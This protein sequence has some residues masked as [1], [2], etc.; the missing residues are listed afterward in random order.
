MRGRC[1][2]ERGGLGRAPCLRRPLT[3]ASPRSAR[4]GRRPRP[5][6]RKRGEANAR[7][8][9]EVRCACPSIASPAAGPGR[10]IFPDLSFAL[11]RGE[12]IAVTGRNGAGKSSLLA[13]LAGR[14]EPESG[15]DRGGGRRRA[16]ACRNA[17]TSSAIATALKTALTAAENLV[18]ARDLLGDP[19][20]MPPRRGPRRGSASPT[21]GAI[22]VAYLSAG[23]RRRIA[24][25]RLLVAAAPAL[26]PRRAAAS[27]DAAAQ[28]TL[29]RD[30]CG[31]TS[32]R[33]ASSSR[34]PT[35]P[36]ASRRGSSASAV[37]PDGSGGRDRALPRRASRRDLD[38][39]RPDRRLGL[40]SASCSS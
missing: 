20:L 26:A 14:L 28:E 9:Q 35:S 15:A 1:R 40:R 24:L 33:A 8:L 37:G 32:K 29:A 18:F 27:L 10:L 21:R 17:C 6:P 34:R 2:R 5:S 23:Q 30:L 4:F 31:G 7:P 19:A 16:R 13:I 11:G 39:R 36:S 25:A 12:A 22:P 3:P 38:A